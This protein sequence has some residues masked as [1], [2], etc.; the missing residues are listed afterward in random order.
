MFLLKYIKCIGYSR[1]ERGRIILEKLSTYQTRGS[2]HGIMRCIYAKAHKQH[3]RDFVMYYKSFQNSCNFK[4]IWEN[5]NIQMQ[6]GCKRLGDGRLDTENILMMKIQTV[7]KQFKLIKNTK[8]QK[9]S[10]NFKTHLIK[11]NLVI[12]YIVLA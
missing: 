7:L 1:K 6:I 11:Q 2:S 5:K 4:Q 8:T 9:N 12:N 10:G 3:L